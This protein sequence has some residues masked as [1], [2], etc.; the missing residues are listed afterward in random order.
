[1]KKRYKMSFKRIPLDVIGKQYN[2]V[3][4]LDYFIFKERKI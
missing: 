2:N 4:W 1:M 3:E